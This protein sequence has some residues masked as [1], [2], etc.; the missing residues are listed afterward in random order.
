MIASIDL[1]NYVLDIEGLNNFRI[2]DEVEVHHCEFEEWN[3][4]KAVIIGIELRRIYGSK[5]LAPSITILHDGD[6]ITDDFE[7]KDLVVTKRKTND[8]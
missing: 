5:S 3:G 7:P 4:T 2:G 8:K 1:A 6:Q